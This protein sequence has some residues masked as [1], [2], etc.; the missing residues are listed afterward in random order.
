MAGEELKCEI[1]NNRFFITIVGE[2]ITGD[3]INFSYRIM[4]QLDKMDRGF[5]VLVD[6]GKAKIN[7]LEGLE[8]QISGSVNKKANKKG[9]SRIAYVLSPYL[10]NRYRGIQLPSY[11]RIFEQDVASARRW[12]DRA[13]LV[14]EKQKNA[15]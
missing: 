15:K 4:R 5:T 9:V 7:I 12:L 14:E 13:A 2:P 3:L 6:L 11:V 1:K 8:Q 10:Y